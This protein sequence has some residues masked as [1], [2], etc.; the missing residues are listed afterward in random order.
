MNVI[1]VISTEP[2]PFNCVISTEVW[3]TPSFEVVGISDDT[4]EVAAELES[5]L[6]QAPDRITIKVGRNGDGDYI[7]DEDFA[8]LMVEERGISPEMRTPGS[9]TCSIGFRATDSKWYGWSHRAWF[10]F[11]IGS[12]CKRGDCGYNAPNATAFGQQ[13]QDFFCDDEWKV[14]AVNRPSVDADG[15]RGVLVTATYTDAVPNEKLRGTEYRHFSEYPKTFGR[16]EWVAET[17]EDARQMAADF[18]EGVS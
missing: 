6:S 11:G 8:R 14:D 2:M 7:G 9:G 3:E 12:T 4:D 15:K 18:A 13:V 5:Q 16:G 1:E 10:G 17:M